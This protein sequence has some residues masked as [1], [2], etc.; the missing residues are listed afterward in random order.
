MALLSMEVMDTADVI[1]NKIRYL[2]L[3]ADPDFAREFAYA[4]YLPHK[5][6]ERFPSISSLLNDIH[7]N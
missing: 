6:L 4:W 1:S 2:E 3:A 7:K 5:D